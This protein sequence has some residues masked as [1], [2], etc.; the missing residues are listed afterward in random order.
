MRKLLFAEVDKLK[1]S[2][3]MV[4]FPWIINRRNVDGEKADTEDILD[5]WEHL[6]VTKAKLPTFCAVTLSRLPPPSFVEADICSLAVLVLNVRNQMGE[7]QV[8]FSEL[9]SKVDLQSAHAMTTSTPMYHLNSGVC[10]PVAEMIAPVATT[11]APVVGLSALAP[12]TSAPLITSSAPIAAMGAPAATTIAPVY[13]YSAPATTD[14]PPS[15][16]QA[17]T[18]SSWADLVTRGSPTSKAAV[19]A[20]GFSLVRVRK[21]HRSPH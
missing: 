10:V 18:R 1:L 19:D 9:A 11:S 4:D 20:D 5:L 7:M 6:D 2:G 21:R 15:A 12:T 13:T 3:A 16:P 14:H 17:S 8:K